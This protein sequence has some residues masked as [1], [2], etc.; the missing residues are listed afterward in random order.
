MCLESV[1]VILKLN[2]NVTEI[3]KFHSFLK[4]AR[5]KLSIHANCHLELNF[6]ASCNVL[7]NL[8]MMLMMM[9]SCWLVD[10]LSQP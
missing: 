9:T 6:L 10:E 7:P 3:L 8:K 4:M 2:L 5:A 1:M